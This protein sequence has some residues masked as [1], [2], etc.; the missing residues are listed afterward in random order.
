VPFELR[1]EALRKVTT[2]TLGPRE[3][4][5]FGLLFEGL[6][7]AHAHVKVPSEFAPR[8]GADAAVLTTDKT[9]NGL[10]ADV[11]A[12]EASR[13]KTRTKRPFLVPKIQES[14]G[15]WGRPYLEDFR[16]AVVEMAEAA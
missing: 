7:A 5:R 2:R 9:V 14:S 11:L 3:P 6:G 12:R 8:D 1:Q 10:L 16:T 13:T 15:S 4:G